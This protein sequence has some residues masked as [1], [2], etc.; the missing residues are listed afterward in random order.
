MW[1]KQ[2]NALVDKVGLCGKTSGK[3][4]FVPAGT[5]PAH[6]APRFAK[7]SVSS[8]ATYRGK[9]STLR[10][11][12]LPMGLG[13]CYLLCSADAERRCECYYFRCYYNV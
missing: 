11:E 12:I 9:I 3:F 5:S 6:H 1:G 10:V 8:H 2:E 7:Y 13:K 4:F